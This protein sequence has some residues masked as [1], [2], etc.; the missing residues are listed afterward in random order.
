MSTP[1]N[2]GRT[3]VVV[4][5]GGY[6]GTVAA[7]R[8]RMRADVE[9]TLVNLRPE[10]VERV[11]LHQL[12][13]GTGTATASFDS[14]LGEKIR[15]VV[16][17][18]TRIDR[19]GGTVH[20]ETGDSLGYDYVIYAVGSICQLPASVP[21]A[22]D[23]AIPIAD[24]ES[25]QRLRSTLHSLPLDAP[26]T[27]VGGGLTGIVTA[28]EL[29]EQGRHVTVVCGGQLAPSLSG[30]VQRYIAH[31]LSR[32]DVTVLEGERVVE[33]GPDAITLSDGST[34]ASELTIWAAGFS[35]PQLAENS[36]LR[37]DDIGRLLTDETLTSI[38]DDRIVATGDAAAPS[39]QPL[40]MSCQATG[41]LGA[42]AADTILNRIAGVEPDAIDLALVGSCVSLGRHAGARQFAH[43]D[44][45]AIDVYLRGRA[46]AAYK[47]F[48]SKLPLR[49]I[50][51]EARKPGSLWWPKGGPRPEQPVMNRD[52]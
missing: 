31:W 16:D 25:A 23:F 8:L 7:N 19:I 22:I 28:A 21:G 11:R 40:R 44:D 43:K 46:G 5:G 37:T 13:A 2:R 34:R 49:K 51:Q 45:V 52:R 18:A 26:I 29:A 42:Q 39:G 47:E 24:Y 33:V 20:L 10:F 4:I 6:A 38:D 1:E 15:L 17:R 12:V 35:V 32:H 50:R 27:V 41:A 36:G 3:R 48:S 14:L 9:I 30:R